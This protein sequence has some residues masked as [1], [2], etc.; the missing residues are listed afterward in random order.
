[1]RKP[2]GTKPSLSQ[3]DLTFFT[4]R[5]LGKAVPRLLQENGL[6]V[7]RYFD[8]FEEGLRV[9]DNEWL[10]YVA[11]R[12]WI[13][14]SHDNNIRHDGE[15]VRTLM[16]SS[17]RLFILRGKIPSKD[18][19]AMFLQAESTV[20]RLLE[21]HRQ[22]FIANVRRTAHRG[23]VVKAAARMML[24]LAE[25]RAGRAPVEDEPSDE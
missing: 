6:K 2:S 20:V 11:A 7:E 14:L 3:L 22:A 15:A 13:A 9:P 19:A 8:H 4:D 21:N 24:T 17:G 1:L 18:L 10:K 16:E 23:G 5:D 12:G 25:W